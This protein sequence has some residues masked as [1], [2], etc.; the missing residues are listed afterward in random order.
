[1]F[2]AEID[3]LILKPLWS[4]IEGT[5]IGKTIVEKIKIG[6]CIFPNFKTYYKA[7]VINTM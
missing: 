1:M 7:K 6:G 2:F 4:K 3:K 5:R